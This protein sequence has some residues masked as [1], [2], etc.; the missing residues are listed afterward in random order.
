MTGGVGAP[1]E[2][3]D[4]MLFG[5]VAE[6]LSFT[7]AAER[8]GLSQ[9]RL[10]QRIKRL[11]RRL[12]TRLL[13]RSTRHVE[14]TDAG[15]RV[16]LAVEQMAAAWAAARRDLA[17]PAPGP[18]RELAL[19][20]WDVVPT[21]LYSYV[22]AVDGRAGRLI[23]V[24]SLDE[25]L[26]DVATGVLDALVWFQL[27][28]HE[29]HVVPPGLVAVTA[30]VE[31]LHVL[32][33]AD[34]P[35]AARDEVRLAE[36]ADETWVVRVEE[37]LRDRQL[38]VLRAAGIRPRVGHVTGS[39]DVVRLVVARDR[40]VI[41]SS[42]MF[43]TGNATVLRPLAD[44]VDA[45][46]YVAADLRRVGRRAVDDVVSLVRRWYV[47]GL[48]RYDSPWLRR[49]AEP[50]AHPTLRAALAAAAEPAPPG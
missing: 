27:P 38:A 22:T 10:S 14:L 7:R 49:M 23:A 33:A 35:L 12:G 48:A 34:H 25:G 3:D 18:A 44:D 4:L 37:P 32:L 31:R 1:V 36:L 41:L 21:R 50:S 29:P 13:D 16:F 46:F 11:E 15:R 40:S 9:P 28:P 19:G 6:E 43:P 47:D 17:R 5:V 45:R 42:P 39:M 24:A 8:L 26:R 20:F 30:V 2:W